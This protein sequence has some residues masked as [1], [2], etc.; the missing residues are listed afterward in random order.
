[1]KIKISRK[2]AKETILWLKLVI[3]TN[4]ENLRDD[5]LRLIQEATE[6]RKFVC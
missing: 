2:I 4:F 6:L 5:G 1:M 3:E